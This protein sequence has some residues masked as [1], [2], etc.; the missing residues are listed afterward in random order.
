MLCLQNVVHAFIIDTMCEPRSE[1][2][3]Q[4]GESEK[5]LYAFL[6]GFASACAGTPEHCCTISVKS[7]CQDKFMCHCKSE[8]E[9]FNKDLEP[10]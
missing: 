3:E 10:R 5:D 4:E 1:K 6:A 9:D 8:L 2:I 7:P